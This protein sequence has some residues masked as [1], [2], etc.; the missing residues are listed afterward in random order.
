LHGTAELRYV[1]PNDV[2]DDDDDYD[3]LEHS[4]LVK[5][6]VRDVYTRIYLL[7]HAV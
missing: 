7:T 3:A 4:T 6:S 2:D 1:A 5:T